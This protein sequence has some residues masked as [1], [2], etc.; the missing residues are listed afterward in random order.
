MLLL[1]ANGTNDK[2][3]TP[4]FNSLKWIRKSWDTNDFDDK[5]I[6]A[7]IALEFIVSKEKNVEMMDKSTRKKC[8]EAI[9]DV[10]LEKVNLDEE[11]YLKNI[12]EKFD[13]A[14]TETPF[15]LK[16]TNL[17]NRLNIPISKDEFTLI[18]NARKQRNG[19]IHGKDDM[20]LP[21]DEVFRLLQCISKIAFYKINSLEV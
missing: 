5:I 12:F 15:M 16:L 6:N 18:S 9:K 19:I 21:T 11:G 2:E 14:Y 20:I 4:L 1:K 10:I 8:K 13:R 7:I 3:I 17:I